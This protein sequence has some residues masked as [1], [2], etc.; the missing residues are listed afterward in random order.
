MVMEA[1]LWRIYHCHWLHCG[2]CWSMSTKSA[3]WHCSEL[4]RKTVSV[5]LCCVT[6]YTKPSG[7]KQQLIVNIF[8]DSLV[9]LQ[10]RCASFAWQ[11]HVAARSAG[12]KGWDGCPSHVFGSGATCWLRRLTSLP[13]GLLS[14][15]QWDQFLCRVVS[16]QHSKRVEVNWSKQ[17]TPPAQIQRCGETDS[18]PR[19]EKWQNY[20]AQ[21]PGSWNGRNLQPL[22]NVPQPGHRWIADPRSE[23]R[24]CLGASNKLGNWF[25]T[26]G[27]VAMG[28]TPFIK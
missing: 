14:S 18:S 28:P 25:W 5:S 9:W 16:G 27:P 17:V 12:S 6:K 22:N 19:Q 2:R 11:L 15:S 26:A 7:L 13:W 3:P 20:S 24:N 4:Q 21:G 10:G 1:G 23:R 8:W